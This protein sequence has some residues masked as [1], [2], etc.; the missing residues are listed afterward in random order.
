MAVVSLSV[1]SRC[2]TPFQSHSEAEAREAVELETEGDAWAKV[3]FEG[4]L[5]FPANRRPR[6]SLKRCFE[7]KSDEI[8]SAWLACWS[9]QTVG[10][11]PL[12]DLGVHL[13]RIAM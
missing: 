13:A 3:F 11:H 2:V 8:M 6:C 7:D 9:A 1:T 10:H 5:R 12:Q 4:M